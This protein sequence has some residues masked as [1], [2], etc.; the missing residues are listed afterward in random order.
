MFH[1]LTVPECQHPGGT[2]LIMK[3]D[4]VERNTAQLGEIAKFR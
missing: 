3:I 2:N 4:G 1:F